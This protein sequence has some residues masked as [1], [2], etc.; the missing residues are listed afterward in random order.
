[1]SYAEVLRRLEKI[2]SM[3]YMLLNE[4]QKKEMNKKNFDYY[5]KQYEYYQEEVAKLEEIKKANTNKIRDYL[6]V[7]N[8]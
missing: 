3:L 5:Q 8:D 2:E 6:E 4:E 1:M 7:N